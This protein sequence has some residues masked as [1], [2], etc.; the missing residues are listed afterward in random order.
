MPQSAR[1]RAVLALT[2]AWGLPLIA[3]FLLNRRD[4]LPHLPEWLRALGGALI[5][6]S[7]VGAAGLAQSLAGLVIAGLIVFSW[8][9]LGDLV[10][11]SL[12]LGPSPW[13]AFGSGALDW[14]A[15]ALIGSG[16]WS[17]IWFFLGVSHLYRS[18]VAVP[19]LGVGL[20]LAAR[21]WAAERA[22]RRPAGRG[23]RGV[24]QWTLIAIV[25]ILALIAALAPPTAT[26]TLLYHLALPKAYLA[27]GGMVEVPGNIASY[28]PLGV[29]MHGVWAM[30]AGQLLAPRIAEI[31]AGATIFAFAP[32]LTLV[33]YGWARAR[34]LDAGLSAIAAVTVATIPSAYSVAANGFVDLALAG[35]TLL[36]LSASGRWWTTGDPRWLVMVA[37]GVG[38][39][40]SAKLSAVLLLVPLAVL[41][42]LRAL[43]VGQEAGEADRRRGA[44][45]ITGLGALAGGAILAS[46]W[47]IRTW[48]RTGSPLFPFYPGLWPG[49]ASGWDAERAQLYE[50]MFQLYGQSETALDYLL[51]PFRLAV[52]AQ[53]GLPSYYDGVLGVAFLF[54]TPLVAWALWRRRLDAELRI[55]ALISVTMFALW[56]LGSQQLRYLLPAAP[57]LAVAMVA[58]AA[59][60]EAEGGPGLGR[61][62]RGLLLAAAGANALVVLAWFAEADP[63]RVVLGGERREA[64][65]ARRLDYYPYYEL[66]NRELPATARVWLI[67]L[68]RDTYYL[69]RPYFADF[70]FEDYTLRQWVRAARDPAEVR[71]RARQAGITHVLVRHDILFD[72]ARSNIVDDRLSREDNLARLRLMGAFLT[73]G[74]RLIRGD[75]RFWLIELA[76]G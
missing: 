25:Q 20:A 5:G 37:A 34:G 46:P 42:L 30:L 61:V 14:G 54:G 13:G 27:G 51:A 50:A 36:A 59:A 48:A 33:T 70:M 3:A 38:W 40:L 66:A 8:W 1:Q 63:V 2:A 35:Y 19:A 41:V 24:V 76:P 72:Y 12:R 71:T 62:L 16:L 73:E 58:A 44:L 4:D 49:H 32:L 22:E 21:G 65:L 57:P 64:Y 6:G 67:N 23:P 10:L 68:R 53:M 45:L 7:A 52:A 11:R 43:R 17:T 9:G 39:A 56:L 69:D 15:R 74:T 29:E 60:A 28:Y 75:Q 55:G 31:A 26:D 18:S 47:Y